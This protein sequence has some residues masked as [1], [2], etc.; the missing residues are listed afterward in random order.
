MKTRR[1]K[2]GVVLLVVLWVLV[3]FSSLVLALSY[4]ARG[5]I[6]RTITHV[7]FIQGRRLAEAGVAR[8][9]AEILFRKREKESAEDA[10]RLDGTFYEGDMETG[11]YR[12]SIRDEAGKVDIN[13]APEVLLRN[14]IRYGLG[15]DEIADEVVD[16]ILD[17]RDRDE[18]H[19]LEGAESDY[20]RSLPNP[21]DA[22]N[23]PFSTVE[24]LSMVRGIDDALL[25]GKGEMTGLLKLVTV[26]A[27]TGRV[28]IASA[29]EE[30]L[31]A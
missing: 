23:G 10:W 31:R 1:K 22:K 18:L 13:F 9:L 25:F 12:V 26:H 14:L 2:S 27:K 29:P 28:N 11:R 15:R 16:S 4:E 24:E 5:N 20:Y 3:I 21:Y 6:S 19:R 8:A 17:W 30:V 7:N